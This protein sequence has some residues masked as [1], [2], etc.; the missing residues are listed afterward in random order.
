MECGNDAIG[1]GLGVAALAQMHA[2]TKGG[3]T[4]TNGGPLILRR[5]DQDACEH[6]FG[7]VRLASKHGAVTSTLAKT[8]QMA[9]SA[10]RLSGIPKGNGRDCRLGEQCTGII[11]VD[12]RKHKPSAADIERESIAVAW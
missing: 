12:L 9:S 3:Y 10:H 7:N 2:K 1:L 5:L 6:H 11:A 4:T 8:C